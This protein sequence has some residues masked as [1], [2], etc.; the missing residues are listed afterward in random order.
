MKK[1]FRKAMAI[2]LS[3]AMV[4]GT[5]A[6]SSAKVSAAGL[7]NDEKTS[8]A[9]NGPMQN[10][11]LGKVPVTYYRV[12]EGSATNLTNGNYT[13]DQCAL[14]GGSGWGAHAEVYF[15]LDLGDYYKAGSLNE[16]ILVYKDANANDTVLNRTYNVQ[17]SIDNDTFDTVYTSGTITEFNDD[18]AT[19]LDLSN[20]TGNVRYIKVDY[21]T[22]ADYGIQLREAAVLATNPKKSDM[23][24]CDDPA[25]VTATTSVGKIGFNITAGEDQ[26]DYKY[27]A[28]LDDVNGT[29]LNEN[30]DA[31]VNY[32]YEVPGGN[33]T[34]FVRS[35][36]G[37]AVSPGINSN[38]VYVNT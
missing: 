31:G 32:S 12:P 23:D 24:T 36:V 1:N 29:V 9:G 6:F 21:P 5:F 4:V 27:T 35:H 28:Y 18:K 15:I 20:I 16:L 2:V 14:S 3:L 17:Y 37:M 19:V 25:A 33:H 22:S 30:C 10:M 38:Q 7:S 26:E 11:V 13:S 34:I 8:I